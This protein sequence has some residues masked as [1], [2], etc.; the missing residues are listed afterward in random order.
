M[1]HF[2]DMADDTLHEQLVV[3]AAE[4]RD[5]LEGLAAMLAVDPTPELVQVLQVLPMLRSSAVAAS[6]YAALQLARMWRSA[7]V[8][9]ASCCDVLAVTPRT[10]GW[11]TRNRI[12]SCWICTL[13]KH[14]Q[15]ASRATQHHASTA[16]TV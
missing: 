10:T 9:S 4:Q 12:G 11:L 5:A 2:S 13:T 7:E 16:G 14:E 8:V 1:T 3:Q 15:S 6:C